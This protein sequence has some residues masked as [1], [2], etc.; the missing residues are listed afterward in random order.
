L[1]HNNPPEV[2]GA[3]G[4]DRER[5]RQALD[6][7]D[8]LADE[9]TAKNPDLVR[10]RRSKSRLVRFAIA[11]AKWVGERAT[12]FTDE[13]LKSMAKYVGP[14]LALKVSGLLPPIVDALEAVARALAH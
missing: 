8:A 2:I 1:G 14:A 3:E 7:V 6:D 5:F 12:N 11:V 4:L 10:V 9:V 13:S